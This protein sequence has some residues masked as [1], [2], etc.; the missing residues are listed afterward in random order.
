M[1]FKVKL[2]FISAVAMR[3]IW[4][5][6]GRVQCT[7]KDGVSWTIR[8]TTKNLI[9][10]EN[11]R[12]IT[13]YTAVTSRLMTIKWSGLFYSVGVNTFRNPTTCL[14]SILKGY[15]FPLPD[16]VYEVVGSHIMPQYFS[17]IMRWK[18]AL[19]Q[20]H[21]ETVSYSKIIRHTPWLPEP[22][23]CSSRPWV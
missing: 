6:A 19:P 14:E 15:L 5:A 22:S 21:A 8:V 11:G 10:R 4:M 13:S 3:W 18:S 20:K 12:C 23:L 2:P 16:G 9:M 17:R 7:G 1:L